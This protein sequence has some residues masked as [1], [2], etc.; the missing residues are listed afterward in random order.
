MWMVVVLV[1]RPCGAGR[2]GQSRRIVWA[3]QPRV[4]VCC[5]SYP[6]ESVLIPGGVW[7]QIR[8]S[9]TPI[10]KLL[11]N[12]EPGVAQ[13]SLSLAKQNT[14][15][16]YLPA[17][18]TSFLYSPTQEINLFSLFLCPSF[19]FS[20]FHK[21]SVWIEPGLLS[22]WVLDGERQRKR[23]EG[24]GRDEGERTRQVVGTAAASTRGVFS[25]GT[26]LLRL[27]QRPCFPSEYSP[28]LPPL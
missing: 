12:P 18:F 8:P 21:A 14:V 27:P 26:Q 3:A 5:E 4:A 6:P 25:A 11:Q 16:M 13:A 17:S 2:Q 15:P 10:K 22:H 1:G 20:L 19:F 7:D 23:A 9:S 28:S 24:E